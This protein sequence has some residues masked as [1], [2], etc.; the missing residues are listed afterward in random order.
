MVD[1]GKPPSGPPVGDWPRSPPTEPAPETIA[2][3]PKRAK[4]VIV[5]AVLAGIFL[6]STIV[7]GVA[8]RSETATNDQLRNQIDDMEQTRADEEAEAQATPNLAEIARDN[9]YSG[10]NLE[11]TGNSDSVTVDIRRPGAIEMSWL[12]FFMRDIGLQSDAIQQRMAQTR[13]LDGTQEAGSDK[14]TVTWTYHPDS[15]LSAV[16]SVNP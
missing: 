7:L 1:Q 4:G 14:V 16:F 6:S 5:A 15:G 2:P 3:Q 13:A 11:W 8:W 10:S 12:A 9:Y